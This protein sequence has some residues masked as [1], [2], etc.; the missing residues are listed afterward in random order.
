MVFSELLLK[1]FKQ[2][3]ITIVS[4]RMNECSV[5]N[6]LRIELKDRFFSCSCGASQDYRNIWVGEKLRV[7]I[8]KIRPFMIDSYCWNRLKTNLLVKLIGLL[9]HEVIEF[10]EVSIRYRCDDTFLRNLKQWALGPQTIYKMHLNTWSRIN[11][12]LIDW[13]MK[14]I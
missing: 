12:V 8:K 9:V 7:V 4:Y 3:L 13:F 10:I 6:I 2:R 5:F 11:Y 1:V 14:N